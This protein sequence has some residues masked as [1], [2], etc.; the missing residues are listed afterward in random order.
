MS[1]PKVFLDTGIFIAFLNRKDRH[2]AQAVAL[3]SG[4]QVRWSTSALVR[5]EAYSW[6][7]HKHGEEAA[8][9][10]RL[11]L[12]NLEGLQIFETEPRHD[13]D[14]SSVLDRLRG[15]KLT[16]VDAS[17]LALMAEHAIERAWSTDHHLGL[18]GIEVL[19]R[20]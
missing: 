3:F 19:P 7:L 16:Y 5:S 17:S 18:T 12:D 4:P 8:R 10:L 6:F 2:H 14:V 1:A 9:S 20:T 11:F 13:D 15:A